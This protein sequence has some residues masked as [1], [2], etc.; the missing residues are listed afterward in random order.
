MD[1]ILYNP[2]DKIEISNLHGV[3]SNDEGA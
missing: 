1:F 2:K 3:A